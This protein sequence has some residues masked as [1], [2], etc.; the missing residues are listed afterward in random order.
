M[1][2]F[3]KHHQQF[4]ASSSSSRGCDVESGS[5]ITLNGWAR[6]RQPPCQALVHSE[7][8]LNSIW[9]A[10]YGT[11]CLHHIHRTP[12]KP[13]PIYALM[14]ERGQLQSGDGSAGPR[15]VWKAP[16]QVEGRLHH[17]KKCRREVPSRHPML[18]LWPA[19][20][21]ALVPTLLASQS[22]RYK[23]VS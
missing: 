22:S 10:V 7:Q 15:S 13:C 5:C 16:F 21:A 4:C 1:I 23:G 14:T 9:M 20:L 8:T 2:Y 11:G 19:H 18:H 3:N 6:I 12:W 17:Q